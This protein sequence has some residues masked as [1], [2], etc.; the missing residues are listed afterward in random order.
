M[1]PKFLES[2]I[3][4]KSTSDPPPPYPLKLFKGFLDYFLYFLDFFPKGT[5]LS[6]FEKILIP[7]VKIWKSEKKNSKK[8]LRQQSEIPIQNS[9]KCENMTRKRQNPKIQNLSTPK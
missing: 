2:L 6:D 5:R 7:R 4:L 8:I 1:E 9:S 3:T